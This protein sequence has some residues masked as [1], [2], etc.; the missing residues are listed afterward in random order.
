LRKFALVS[1]D[2]ILIYITS[3]FEH[4]I[5]LRTV[6]QV[7]RENKLY[8]IKS[9]C[10]FAQSEVEYLGH[11]ICDKGVATGPTK[12]DIIKQWP[13]PNTVTDLRAFL[14]MVWILQKVHPRLWDNM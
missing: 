8:A 9:K 7:L 10:S 4:V 1:F 5:H 11:I 6:L 13:E 12:I 3:F 14:G 2:D